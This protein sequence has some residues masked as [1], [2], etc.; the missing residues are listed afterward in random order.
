MQKYQLLL[1]FLGLGGQQNHRPITQ[2]KHAIYNTKK[3]LVGK[4]Q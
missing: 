3:K 2:A 1:N 4:S